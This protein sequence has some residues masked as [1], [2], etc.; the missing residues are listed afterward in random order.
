MTDSTRGT[1]GA[2]DLPTP[3]T[4][5]G[6]VPGQ[7]RHA[8]AGGPAS[9]ETGSATDPST[10]P[11]TDPATGSGAEPPATATSTRRRNVIIAAMVAGVVVIGVV[12]AALAGA[13]DAPAPVV[14]PSA[15][16]VTLAS[17]T[18]TIEPVARTPISTFADALPSS[19]LQFALTAVAPQPTLVTAGALEAYRLDYSDGGTTAVALDAG[20]FETA[21]EATA[22]YTA[23][24]AAA[25]ATD[26]GTVE[27]GGAAVGSWSISAAADGSGVVTWTNGTALFSATG[28]ADTVKD[29]YLA[30]PL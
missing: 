9:P 7:G 22:A 1:W 29:F 12:A 10:Q 6:G 26:S 24:V 28:P 8:P 18:P 30:F 13:F 16:T 25:P 14:T 4:P 11:P 27:V 2:E 3:P 21:A 19:V 17:P 15:S 20:Q 5:A 23:L